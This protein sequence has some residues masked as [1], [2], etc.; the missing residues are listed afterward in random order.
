MT[1]ACSARGG[2]AISFVLG[3]FFV[4]ACSGPAG[5][6]GLI[7]VEQT[8]PDAPP[9]APA[10]ECVVT[11]GRAPAS[12]R[13][14][15]DVCSELDFDVYPPPS[16]PHY[17]TWADF[18]VYDT[19]VPWGFLVHS[20]EHGAVVLAHNCEGS[21]PEVLAAFER[22]RAER[23]DPLCR[24]H[25]NGSRVIVVPDPALDVPIAAVA[26]EHVY[27]ATCLDEDSLAAFVDAHYARAPENL[28]APGAS[29]PSCP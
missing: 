23:D 11:T 4:P 19:P 22:I 24:E 8:R 7:D 12:N 3:A 5:S 14:H 27:L 13:N 29:A 9:I 21:C 20:L 17:G 28:C 10:T 26:W 6:S 15:V 25:A 1:T 16:G 18:A 2:S